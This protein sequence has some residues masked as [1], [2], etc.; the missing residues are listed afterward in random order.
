MCRDIP[1]LLGCSFLGSSGSSISSGLGGIGSA[2]S[3]GLGRIC[4]GRSSGG[5]ST[6][7]GVRSGTDSSAGSSSTRVHS[8]TGCSGCGTSGGGSGV[9]R[10]SSSRLSG[11]CGCSSFFFLAA[12]GQSNSGEQAGDQEGLFH[13]GVLWMKLNTVF[14]D[15]KKTRIED[16]SCIGLVTRAP[17]NAR[18]AD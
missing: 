16:P 14:L 7:G 8:S 2:I 4:S 5:S 1:V 15:Q 11:R 9:C 3:G 12:S 13:D 6:S 17:F 10:S 18:P